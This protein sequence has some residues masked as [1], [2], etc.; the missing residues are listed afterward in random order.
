[1]LAQRRACRHTSASGFD[2]KIS[3]VETEWTEMLALAA[4]ATTIKGSVPRH[5][6]SVNGATESVW[7]VSAKH[8][9]PATRP[10]FNTTA[11]PVKS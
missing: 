11:N 2:A 3:C 9:L 5:F 6:R 7:P 8:E 4:Q 10:P 1:M